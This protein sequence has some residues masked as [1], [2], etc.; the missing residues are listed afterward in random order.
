MAGARRGAQLV[1]PIAGAD[2]RGVERERP[3]VRLALR[4]GGRI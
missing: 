4:P 3:R 2:L 1:R